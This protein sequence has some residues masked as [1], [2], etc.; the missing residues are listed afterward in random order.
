LR[1]KANGEE[2]GET[3]WGRKMAIATK[4]VFWRG[5]LVLGA[6]ECAAMQTVH[7]AES[8]ALEWWCAISAIAEPK[9][10][11]RH[12]SATAFNRDRKKSTPQ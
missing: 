12:S 4:V 8:I 3:G 5:T 9:V 11:N 2:C 7:F 10:S 1:A 6:D